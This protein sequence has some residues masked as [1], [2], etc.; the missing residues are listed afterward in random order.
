MVN[1]TEV[2]DKKYIHLKINFNVQNF[3]IFW[4]F[5]YSAIYGKYLLNI[6]EI[7]LNN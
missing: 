1:I 2:I 5:F 6:Y 3:E 4:L 7:N